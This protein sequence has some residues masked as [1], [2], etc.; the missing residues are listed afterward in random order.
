MRRPL[1]RFVPLALVAIFGSACGDDGPLP[2]PDTPFGELPRDIPEVRDSV[3]TDPAGD[4]D[5]AAPDPGP[6]TDQALEEGASETGD[7]PTCPPPGTLIISEVMVNPKVVSDT[8]GEWI[9]LWNLGA[10]PVNL[11]GLEVADSTRTLPIQT[12]VVIE[13]GGV[14]VLARNGDAGVNG[15]VEAQVVLSQMQL[16]NDSGQVRLLCGQ[17][18]LD[19]VAWGPGWPLREGTSLS[20]DPSGAD[21]VRNDAPVWWCRGSAPWAGGDLGS[22]GE[23]NPGCGLS[24]CGDGIHQAWEACDDGNR[25]DGDDCPAD[26]QAPGDQ[27]GDGI[28]DDQDN[29]PDVWNPDQQDRDLDGRGDLCDPPECG[30]RVLETGE[31]CEDGNRQ[32][33][34]GCSAT[35]QQES[36]AVGAIIVT[37]F[38]YDPSVV[39][40][41]SG[42]WIEV[43][44]P[45]AE[46]VDLAGW[47][48]GDGDG[49]RVVLDP[50]RGTTV[51]P[52]GGYLVLGRKGNP[53]EN[54]GV[55]VDYPYGSGFTL[56]NSDKTATGGEPRYADRIRLTWNGTLID[57]VRYGFADL[58]FP[59]ATGRSLQLDPGLLDF[60]FNDEAEAWCTAPDDALLPGGDRG[61][62]GQPNR[63]CPP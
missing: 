36:Y 45:G 48:L 14:A 23:V 13:A 21:P 41:T 53:E 56:S 54:G 40:D 55:P 59:V 61:T 12:P 27:D 50:A 4:P 11:Q 7:L 26:C 30:N 20:L 43:F 57:E 16:G 31:A 19:E 8:A 33:G 25:R 63:E 29:C 44:N 60:E 34:D 51:V 10:V 22:P 32:S 1:F 38:L 39:S 49:D 24:S 62:P 42:E 3:P 46:P 28:R 35:C 9:E 18:L 2:W 5:T 15:G 17:S 47:E 6:G 37:E 52:P 58:K